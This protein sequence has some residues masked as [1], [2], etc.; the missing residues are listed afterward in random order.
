MREERPS[1]D[2]LHALKEHI[3]LVLTTYESGEGGSW[4]DVEEALTE[5][6][7]RL[8]AVEALGVRLDAQLVGNGSAPTGG[9]TAERQELEEFR[10][11]LANDAAGLRSTLGRFKARGIEARRRLH[12]AG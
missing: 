7:G 1:R 9:R 2:P 10:R 8:L 3:D 6:Y 4:G 11:A 12:R 5:G